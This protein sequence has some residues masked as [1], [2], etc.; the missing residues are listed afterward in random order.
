VKIVEAGPVMEHAWTVKTDDEVAIYRAIGRHYT[1]TMTAF[2][3]AIRPGITENELASVVVSAW[4]AAGGEDIAQLNVCS[5]ENMNPW[6]RWPSQRRLEAGEFVGIDLHGR[7]INGLRGDASR[8]YLVGAN[9]TAAQRDLYRAAYDY[10]Y[11]CIDVIRAGRTIQEVSASVP[12]V[13]APYRSQLLDYNIAH[14]MGLGSSGYPHLDPKKPPIDDLLF[15]NQVLAVESYFGEEGSGVA[16][17]L[18]EQIVV[19]DGAPEI[20]GGDMPYD[21]GCLR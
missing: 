19:R 14:G 9:P 10:M 3:G 4:Y 11:G 17:K 21:D 7:G 1:Q 8:T 15:A 16:V 6:R 5:G 12:A 2:R 18:E 13:S 20:L